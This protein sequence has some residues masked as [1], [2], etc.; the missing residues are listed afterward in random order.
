MLLIPKT[1]SPTPLDDQLI[2][3]LTI[4]ELRELAKA[5][6]VTLRPYSQTMTKCLIQ[7]KKTRL[8]T[9]RSILDPDNNSTDITAPRRG[10]KRKAGGL[11]VN[12][13]RANRRIKIEPAD[14]T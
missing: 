10:L 2:D 6:Q 1:P 14:R 9:L 3:R 5:Q 11:P 8:N 12:S 7:E 4:D 13:V